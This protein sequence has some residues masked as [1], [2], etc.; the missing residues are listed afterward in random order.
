M[1]MGAV[2]LNFRDLLECRMQQ[3][4]HME[5]ARNLTDINLRNDLKLWD[6]CLK[7]QANV[8]KILLEPKTK[9]NVLLK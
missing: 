3:H 8:N 2:Y 7:G 6:S 1:G 9:K 4:E 5:I